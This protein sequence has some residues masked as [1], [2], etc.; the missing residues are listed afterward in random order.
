MAVAIVRWFCALLGGLLLGAG[1]VL[2][3]Q[4]A[5]YRAMRDEVDATFFLWRAIGNATF[6]FQSGEHRMALALAEVPEEAIKESDRS[7]WVLVIIG[8][9]VALTGPLLRE[10]SPTRAKKVKQVK[11]VARKS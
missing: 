1:L 3:G 2:H 5:I 9:L 4:V 7:A 6:A 11:Q 10:G 8:S